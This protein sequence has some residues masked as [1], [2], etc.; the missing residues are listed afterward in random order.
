MRL[1]KRRIAAAAL[2][3]GC[4][5]GPAAAGRYEQFTQK[6]AEGRHMRLVAATYFGSEGIEGFVAAEGLPN[7]GVAAFGNA[8]GPSFPSS[9]RP[10]VLGRGRHLGLKSIQTDR[11]GRTTL[12]LENPDVA[13]TVVLYAEGL[14][15]VLKVV[16][17][18]WG[19]ASL[20]A[21]AVSA[22]GKALV[23]AGRATPAFEGLV[24]TGGAGRRVPPPAG[25]LD[26]AG[27]GRRRRPSN[28]GPYVYE[29][30]KCSGDVFVMRFSPVTD[31]IEWVWTLSG[32]QLPPQKLWQD[33]RGTVYFQSHY[34]YRIGP[35]GRTCEP[36]SD[37]DYGDPER[38]GLRA[39]DRKTGAYLIGGDR[40][41]STGR[42][43]WRQPYLYK[44]DP[45]GRKVWTLWEWPSRNLRDGQG[46]DDGLVSDS[47]CRAAAVVPNGDIIV[48]G[49]SDGGN[50]IFTRQPTDIEKPVP[51]SAFGM[52]SWGM[53]GANSLGYLMRIDPASLDVKAWSLWVSYVPDT[54]QTPRERGAPNFANIR[55]IEVL[56]GGQIAWRGQ[57]ATGL[58]QTP[59]AFY[60][61]PAD[62]RKYGGEYVAVFDADLR[63][64]LF[65]SYVPGCED[66]AIGR[67]PGGL[68]IA[69]RSR[70]GDGLADRPTPSPVHRAVQ[71]TKRG[72]YDGHL[73]LLRLPAK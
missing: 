29:K 23:L 47:A 19:V 36:L 67:A 30:T 34:V 33:N 15:R 48:G 52:S 35:D 73:V 17:F 13:G 9:P 57:A 66:V 46:N 55:Q 11:K 50:S 51:R 70:G 72:E 3:V 6:A 39:V 4:L 5:A 20:S 27:R 54:F 8:W 10:V 38:V 26:S 59:N 60:R 40:N 68:V 12:P 24:R 61:H 16:R 58:V 45:S 1:W 37:K 2:L 22:D 53:R 43:P 49:W 32:H 21:G 7:G 42:E 14:Q 71:P 31:R 25:V 28:W 56:D 63:D 62:G 69:S 44:Y 41:T 65:S 64:L 18:D